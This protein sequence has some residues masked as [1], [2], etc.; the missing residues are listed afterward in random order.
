MNNMRIGVDAMGGD[1]APE[2]A[3]LGALDAAFALPESTIVLFGDEA[4]I[5]KVISEQ[6]SI[7]TNIEIVHTTEVIEMAESPTTAF[8][9]KPDSSIVVGF[10]YLAKGAIDAFASAG[11]T[12]AMMVG[13]MYVLKPIEGVLRPTIATPFPTFDGQEII[14][15]DVGLNIDAKPEVLAQYGILGSIFS[16]TVMGVEKPRVALLNIG[17]EQEKGNQQTKPTFPLLMESDINFVGNI[18]GKYLLKGG[19]DV[20]VCDGFVGNIILK[21]LESFEP[22]LS[23]IEGINPKFVEGLNYETYGGTPVIGVSAPVIIGHGC[24]SSTAIKNMILR[25]NLVAKSN[26]IE[27]IK[28]NFNSN[29]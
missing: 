10:G 29:S 8:S 5:N 26:M 12:G 13:C 17:E 7:P 22:M 1:Y 25:A 23:Q 15:L 28:E 24:S 3:V 11:S 9:K 14:L 27:R 21:L 20:V 6:K 4:S 16:E 2:T 19:A 18:E